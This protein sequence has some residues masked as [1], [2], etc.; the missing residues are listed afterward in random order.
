M[1]EEEEEFAGAAEI[2]DQR[3]KVLERAP[4]DLPTFTEKQETTFKK[5]FNKG[6]VDF[7]TNRY[8]RAMKE[9]QK[10]EAGSH[11]YLMAHDMVGKIFIEQGRINDAVNHLRETLLVPGYGVD[12]YDRVKLTLASA[13]EKINDISSSLRILRE[14]AGNNKKNKE[15]SNKIKELEKKLND[16]NSQDDANPRVSY[17]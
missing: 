4:M 8:T 3:M 6:M 1:E 2:A 10:I 11:H 12:E 15:I 16:R 13:Y 17:V 14:M 5:H 7:D 9:F